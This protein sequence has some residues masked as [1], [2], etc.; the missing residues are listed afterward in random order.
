MDK[1][2]ELMKQAIELDPNNPTLF[3]NLGVVNAGQDKTEE[4]KGYYTKA[5]ELKPDYADAYMNLAAL[6]L[7]EEKAI[8]EEMNKNLSNFDKYDEL[9]GKQKDVYRKALPY[10]EKAD[11]LKRSTDTVRSLLNIYDILEMEE[12]ADK[13]RP[14]Y[15][16]MRQ[17]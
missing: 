7:D 10:L 13:L 12:K 6:I 5:I 4:A 2:G 11:E 9:E 14:I 17:G 1:F 8:V 16:E 15:K 3:Y